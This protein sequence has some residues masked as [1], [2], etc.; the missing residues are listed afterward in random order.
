MEVRRE[1][2]IFNIFC[3]RKLLFNLVRE[4]IG[5]LHGLYVSLCRANKKVLLSYLLSAIRIEYC[6][7]SNASVIL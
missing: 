1:N 6:K 5:H 7:Q 2:Q 3:A 4:L